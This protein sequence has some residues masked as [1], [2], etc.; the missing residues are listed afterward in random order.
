MRTTPSSHLAPTSARRA[1]RSGSRLDLD[2]G[3]GRLGVTGRHRH[4]GS[5]LLA[6][7]AG[8][9]HLID[10]HARDGDYI[11]SDTERVSSTDTP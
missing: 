8:G 2:T 6:A 10:D 5:R 4:P 9:V 7:A 11:T 3:P 1:C